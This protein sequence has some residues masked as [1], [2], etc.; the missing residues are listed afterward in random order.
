[1]KTSLVIFLVLGCLN[2]WAQWVP[3]QCHPMSHNP[4]CWE[5]PSNPNGE[6][7]FRCRSALACTTI[8]SAQEDGRGHYQCQAV[9]GERFRCDDLVREFGSDLSGLAVQLTTSY[10]DGCHVLGGCGG[11]ACVPSDYGAQV[12]LSCQ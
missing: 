11:R 9:S 7:A 8:A 3:N 4:R 10:V 2:G 5:T 1:M 6:L 12:S